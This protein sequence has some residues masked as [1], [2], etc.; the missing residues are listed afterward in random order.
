[1]L[2]ILKVASILIFICAVGLVGLVIVGA[3]RGDE[4]IEELLKAPGAIENFKKTAK[5]TEPG[6]DQISPLV[7]FAKDFSLRI[8]PPPPPEPVKPKTIR[9]PRVASKR[10]PE[11]PRPKAPVK[12]KFDLLATCRYE[13]MPDRSLALL[14]LPVKGIKWYRQGE[15]VGHLTIEQVKDG[16][17]VCSDGQ[18][19]FVPV[20]KKT[21]KTL[22]KSEL[23]A[24]LPQAGISTPLQAAESVVDADKP[25]IPQAQPVTTPARPEN[26]LA[27]RRRVRRLP[28]REPRTIQRPEPTAQEKRENISESIATIKEIM[29]QPDASGDDAEKENEMKIWSELL[30]SL[31]EE[32][33]QIEE[34]NE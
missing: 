8:N 6:E 27:T 11:P 26:D 30:Q 5:K 22:L 3:I 21:T 20:S 17:I 4:Q 12:A 9:R 23:A 34:N 13:Q 7:K 24:L 32:Q 28:P 15:D 14:A 33:A 16:S 18:E 19:I 31:E 29:S 2:K 1:M 25:T 10:T